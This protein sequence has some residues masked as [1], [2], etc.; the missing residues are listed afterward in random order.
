MLKFAVLAFGG[1]LLTFFMR[2][3][4]KYK[5]FLGYTSGALIAIA[6][7]FLGIYLNDVHN[8]Q[9]KRNKVIAQLKAANEAINTYNRTLNLYFV[10]YPNDTS[11]TSKQYWKNQMPFPS[12]FDF[13]TN[14][15]DAITVLSSRTKEELTLHLLN[16]HNSIKEITDNNPSNRFMLKE[17]RA[18]RLSMSEIIVRDNWEVQYQKGE[19]D[20]TELNHLIGTRNHYFPQD[21]QKYVE[22]NISIDLN[23]Y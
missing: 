14:N 18:L 13:L 12:V 19:I 21:F 5:D 8:E 10:S 22:G 1:A 11:H 7:I 2:R 9:D 4:E 6:L 15:E 17:L 23:F 3:H 20:Y 16:V